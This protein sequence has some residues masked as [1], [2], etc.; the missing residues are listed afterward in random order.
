MFYFKHCCITTVKYIN[1][2]TRA[3]HDHQKCTKAKLLVDPAMYFQVSN[4]KRMWIGGVFQ[5]VII[6]TVNNMVTT[7]G[8]HQAAHVSQEM[9]NRTEMFRD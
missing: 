1:Y 5:Q 9:A 6:N 4:L 8:F 2:C 7:S 3:W